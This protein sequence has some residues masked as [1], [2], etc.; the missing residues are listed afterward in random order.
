[1]LDI[2]VRLGFDNHHE[3]LSIADMIQDVQ[4]ENEQAY[5]G[6]GTTFSH[7]VNNLVPEW[8]TN[9]LNSQTSSVAKTEEIEER[10]E[11]DRCDDE[12]SYD[13]SISVKEIP[14]SLFTV[15]PRRE[16]P[17][18]RRAITGWRDK[19]IDS[20]Q[21]LHKLRWYC[22]KTFHKD[23]ASDCHKIVL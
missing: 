11:D 13:S 15:N 17:W 16:W 2:D 21:K 7:T 1:M 10:E 3:S 9:M 18:K 22:V 12:D 4:N 19:K 20:I 5:N 8:I 23:R 14:S 6:G